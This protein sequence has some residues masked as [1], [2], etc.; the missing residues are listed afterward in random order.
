MKRLLIV[1]MLCM[2]GLPSV[3][4]AA[5]SV[6]PEVVLDESSAQQKKKYTFKD[7]EQLE[8]TDVVYVSKM[9]LSMAK[10]FMPDV[11]GNGVDVK[12]LMKDLTGVHIISVE[13]RN[14][15]KKALSILDNIIASGKYEVIMQM[16][17]AGSDDLIFYYKE[18][19]K[20]EDAEMLLVTNEKGEELSI[21]RLK[22]TVNLQKLK[23]LTD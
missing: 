10:G 20:K 1:L 21:I 23:E 12:G 16:K 2:F 7:L 8:G 17:E 18:A 6:E 11:A 3:L 22:G 13:N 19:D 4:S 14:S 15:V 9:M 5:N